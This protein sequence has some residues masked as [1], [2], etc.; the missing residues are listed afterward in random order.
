MQ[1]A[2]QHTRSDMQQAAA[3]QAKPHTVPDWRLSLRLLAGGCSASP[4]LRQGTESPVPGSPRPALGTQSPVPAVPDRIWLGSG[5]NGQ[6]RT[7]FGTNKVLMDC[8]VLIQRMVPSFSSFT[9][10]P[11]HIPTK[12][13]PISSIFHSSVSIKDSFCSWTQSLKAL[14][15]P[16]RLGTQSPVPSSPVRPSRDRV[17][18]QALR[19]WTGRLRQ[20]R[21]G[22]CVAWSTS[23]STAHPRHNAP[24]YARLRRQS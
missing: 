8:K 5:T 9:V 14:S 4:S 10:I 18:V 11:R 7:R 3:A 23:G 12:Y 17:P 1:A 15:P 19:A 21:G 22:L 20:S 13:Q 6:K 2:D 24:A 16:P